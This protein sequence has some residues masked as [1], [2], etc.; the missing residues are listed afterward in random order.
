MRVN[1]DEQ[2]INE[3]RIKRMARRLSKRHDRGIHHTE[4]LGRLIG[5]WML[6]Y[7]RR[8]PVLRADD[9][10]IA[11]DLDGF[12]E[13]MITDEMADTT[14]AEDMI[15]VRGVSDRI[16]FLE[17][18]TERGRKGGR[19]AGRG[20]EQQ[21]QAR[22]FAEDEA[23]AKRVLERTQANAKRHQERTLS[24]RLRSPQAYSPDQ[25]P[26]QALA[27]DQDHVPTRGAGDVQ[28]RQA[29]DPE[30]GS[31]LPVASAKPSDPTETAPETE[32]RA[33]GKPPREVPVEAVTL[34]NVLLGQICSNHPSG[35]AAKM[36]PKVAEVTALRWAETIDKLHRIDKFSWGE[37]EG[38][39]TWSQRH[40]FWRTV[41]LGA[42]NLRDKWDQ[43][44]AQRNRG[45]TPRDTQPA[46]NVFDVLDDYAK[47]KDAKDK[48]PTE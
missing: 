6:C 26:D 16:A 42:D 19:V 8:S 4:V 7:S 9:V 24:E 29:G 21:A 17:R 14:H 25:A 41:I 31:G 28:Q 43:M 46:P 27:L 47:E 11:A 10:D 23:L 18:Q 33:T 40:S 37:I 15:H 5:V 30:K 13:A 22:L 2:A 44:A 48:E 32:N 39:I 34:A 20:P 1:V 12:A 45:A 38:M 36:P 35:R 3:P